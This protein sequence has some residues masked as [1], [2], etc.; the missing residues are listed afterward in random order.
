MSP[1]WFN[2][3]QE[4]LYTTPWTIPKPPDHSLHAL[5]TTP[6]PTPLFYFLLY[7]YII[8]INLHTSYILYIL[9]KIFTHP[10]NRLWPLST[11]L[12]HYTTNTI[13]LFLV[14]NLCNKRITGSVQFLIR[15]CSQ[16]QLSTICTAWPDNTHKQYKI[17]LVSGTRQSRHVS[18]S[19]SIRGEQVANTNFEWWVDWPLTNF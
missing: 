12:T 16:S 19:K 1:D 7:S 2:V 17:W 4:I 9:Q 3:H 6:P 13:I 18:L 14:I 5:P 15:S 11:R 8:I 10:M